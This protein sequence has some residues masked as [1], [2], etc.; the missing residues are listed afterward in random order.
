MDKYYRG[1]IEELYSRTHAVCFFAQLF[2]ASQRLSIVKSTYPRPCSVHD[3]MQK[4]FFLSISAQTVGS[5]LKRLFRVP[6]YERVWKCQIYHLYT[7]RVK[8][9]SFSLK[10]NCSGYRVGHCTEV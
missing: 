6:M 7:L 1:H 10:K 4:I 2:P 8:I 3:H 9:L 5:E